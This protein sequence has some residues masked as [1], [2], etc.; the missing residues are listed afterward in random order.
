MLDIW[1]PMLEHFTRW[2]AVL[3][4]RLG[5]PVLPFRVGIHADLAAL[6]P[7][8]DAGALAAL[9]LA[10]RQHC[11]SQKYMYAVARPGA[12]RHDLDAK[13]VGP[14]SEA[15]ARMARIDLGNRCR[16]A[17]TKPVGG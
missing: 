8:G 15:E 3:P 14:V 13:P 4:N 2:P 11:R 6:L 7:P 16:P 9:K 10:L 5:D 17:A 1:T 12:Q